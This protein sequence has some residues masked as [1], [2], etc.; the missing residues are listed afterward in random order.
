MFQSYV[1]IYVEIDGLG[2]LIAESLCKIV[3]DGIQENLIEGSGLGKNGA[4]L[5]CLPNFRL[6]RRSG[7]RVIEFDRLISHIAEAHAGVVATIRVK[8]FPIGVGTINETRTR[9][10]FPRCI[11]HKFRAFENDV[12]LVVCDRVPTE[13]SKLIE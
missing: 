2:G 3:F 1:G 8:N 12:P 4:T 9:K 10:T 5:K 13:H 7:P 6:I 11:Q